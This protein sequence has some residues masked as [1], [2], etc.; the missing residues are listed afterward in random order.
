MS[1]PYTEDEHLRRVS[2]YP[3]LRDETTEYC[4][5]FFLP[6][7]MAFG[8]KYPDASLTLVADQNTRDLYVLE[9]TVRRRPRIAI[10]F[11]RQ[12]LDEWISGSGSAEFNRRL[13]KFMNEPGSAAEEKRR[14]G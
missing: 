13:E 6:G 12:E 7:L 2:T 4:R 10:L 5:D 11:S 3:V 1:I 9:N 14:Y 8:S